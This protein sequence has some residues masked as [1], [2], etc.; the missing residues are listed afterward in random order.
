MYTA[1]AAGEPEPR[2]AGLRMF[3]VGP[4][5]ATHAMTTVWFTVDV[6]AVSLTLPCAAATTTVTWKA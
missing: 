3:N 2:R 1:V 5:N 6:P 4:T